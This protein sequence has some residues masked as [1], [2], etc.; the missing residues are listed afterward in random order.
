MLSTISKA[1]GAFVARSTSIVAFMTSGPMLRM[2]MRMR[3]AER[4][5]HWIVGVSARRDV[6]TRGLARERADDTQ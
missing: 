5:L 1:S 2:R 6:C 3:E 4:G